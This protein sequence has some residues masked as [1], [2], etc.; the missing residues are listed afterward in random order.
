VLRN[1]PTIAHA[2]SDA[3]KNR[4]DTKDSASAPL[5][6]KTAADGKLDPI[7]K[8]ESNIAGKNPLSRES[9]MRE[10]GYSAVI[11]PAETVSLKPGRG[12]PLP[13][14]S[15][16]NP[17][18]SNKESWSRP[19]MNETPTGTPAIVPTGTVRFG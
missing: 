17:T 10:N 1:N 12:D 16:A 14:C 9:S 18:D 8:V 4:M 11:S 5:T 15:N 7:S 19:P 13:A 6:N 3:I 2:A